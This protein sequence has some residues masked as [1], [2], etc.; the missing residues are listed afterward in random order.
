MHR[1]GDSGWI[2]FSVD[3]RA[4]GA[5]TTQ[6]VACVPGGA[7]PGGSAVQLAAG[8]CTRLLQSEGQQQT[9]GRDVTVRGSEGKT[10]YTCEVE[11]C[12][13][14]EGRAR[15]DSQGHSEE[16]HGGVRRC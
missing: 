12:S 1:A 14:G 10:I 5:E 15:A 7:G 13:T 16:G 8:K 3:G 11:S 2:E 4:M 9:G 6:T